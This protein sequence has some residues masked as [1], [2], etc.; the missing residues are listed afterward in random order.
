MPRTVALP[1]G[2]DGLSEAIIDIASSGDNTVIS[3]VAGTRIRVYRIFAIAAATVAVTVKDGAS[4]ALTGAMTL[5]TMV[6]DYDE[7]PW[8]TCTGNNAFILNL[9]DAVQVSGRVYYIQG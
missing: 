1:K 9:G 4:T 6:L 7:C 8:F 3:A 2:T 5:G